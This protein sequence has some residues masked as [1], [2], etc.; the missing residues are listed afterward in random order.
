MPDCFSYLMRLDDVLMKIFGRS[1]HFFERI[2]GTSQFN[3][4]T[5]YLD[6][7]NPYLYHYHYIVVVRLIH[8]CEHWDFHYLEFA[9]AVGERGWILVYQ[10]KSC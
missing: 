6:V 5:L 1:Q 8:N 10:L 4:I 7:V 3:V 9:V 2:S